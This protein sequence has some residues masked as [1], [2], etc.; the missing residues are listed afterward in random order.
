MEGLGYKS[1]K[2]ETSNDW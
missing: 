1:T 2:P